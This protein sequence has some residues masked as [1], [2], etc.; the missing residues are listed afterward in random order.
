MGIWGFCDVN[1]APGCTLEWPGASSL[2]VHGLDCIV[3][4]TATF[5]QR[6]PFKWS[7]SLWFVLYMMTYAVF[8][9]ALFLLF[10]IESPYAVLDWHAPRRTF[11][12]IVLPIL[13]IVCPL[14]ISLYWFLER[15][16]LH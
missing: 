1:P 8:S 6:V 3:L 10:G 14:V 11:T 2:W 16:R 9:Y 5:Y 13:F 4:T 15:S 12:H 7:N